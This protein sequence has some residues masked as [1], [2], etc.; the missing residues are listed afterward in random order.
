MSVGEVVTAGDSSRNAQAFITMS[1]AVYD[2]EV[3]RA[4]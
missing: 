4:T 3:Q 1:P 2:R